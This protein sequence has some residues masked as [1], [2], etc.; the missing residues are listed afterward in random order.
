MMTAIGARIGLWGVDRGISV[1]VA[2]LYVALP[3]IPPSCAAS[4]T[5]CG[6]MALSLSN[7]PDASTQPLRGDRGRARRSERTGT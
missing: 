1:G 6:H 3:R 5:H 7:Q 2:A 4:L